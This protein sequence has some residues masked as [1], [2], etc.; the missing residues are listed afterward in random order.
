[1]SPPFLESIFTIY[2]NLIYVW[3]CFK[4]FHWYV[5]EEK[6]RFCIW[7]I[8]IKKKSLT[9]WS[10]SVQPKQ[11]LYLNWCHIYKIY[12]VNL[13]KNRVSRGHLNSYMCNIG[14]IWKQ[15]IHL[16]DDPS[17]DTIQF[18]DCITFAFTLSWRYLVCFEK[19]MV[20]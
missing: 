5:R 18:Q 9:I 8:F 17:F 15:N 20:N 12:S 6:V 13:L 3:T 4:C 7:L 2:M 19:H 10:I 14:S 16:C 1:M 11:L